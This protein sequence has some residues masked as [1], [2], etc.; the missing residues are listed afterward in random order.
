MCP[1][2][3]AEGEFREG[4]YL[5]RLLVFDRNILFVTLKLIAGFRPD[6]FFD[7]TLKDVGMLYGVLLSEPALPRWSPLA[8]RPLL[9]PAPMHGGRRQL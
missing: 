1:V 8:S 4:R 7:D 3:N 9:A 6:F 2:P 5:S